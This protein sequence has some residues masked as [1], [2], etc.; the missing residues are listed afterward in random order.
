MYEAAW[1]LRQRGLGALLILVW[2]SGVVM[3]QECHLT[4]RKD[5]YFL[6]ATELAGETCYPEVVILKNETIQ[7]W[8]VPNRGRF[9]FDLIRNETG[10]SQLVAITTPSPL[11]FLGAYI[12]EFGG[13]Y[14][15][16]PWHKRDNQPMPLDMKVLEDSGDC[17]IQMSSQDPETYIILQVNLEVPPLE[18]EASLKFRLLNP[19]DVDQVINLSVV[20]AARPGGKASEA[21][22]LLLP[23]SSVTVGKSDAEWMGKEGSKV[24]W[25]VSWSK[26]GEFKAAGWFHVATSEF[27]VPAIS[28]YNPRTDEYITISWNPW[29][30]WTFCTFFS[31]GPAYQQV[32]G[33]YDGFRVEL[34]AEGL[35]VQAKMERILELRLA[36][37]SG[38]PAYG[39]SSY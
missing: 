20:I 11:N 2:I 15:T 6:P 35:K 1:K 17:A 5:I 36:T 22:E 32:V 26:W 27:R 19:K 18:P 7:I 38:Y 13:V 37:G 9:V 30:P 24:T 16:F 31:W 28:V 3:G 34:H 39:H 33:A 14:S 25:P 29:D 4:I 21:M 12:F 23:V 8:A 10:N